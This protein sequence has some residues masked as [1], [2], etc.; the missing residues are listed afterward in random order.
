MPESLGHMF[1][2]AKLALVGVLSQFCFAQM[3]SLEGVRVHEPPDHTPVVFD[4]RSS[5]D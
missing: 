1:S 5:A 4:P 2:L 3:N